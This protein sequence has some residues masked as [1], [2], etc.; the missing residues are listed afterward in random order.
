M[1][2]DKKYQCRTCLKRYAYL[3]R[4]YNHVN[5]E[6]HDKMIR[7]ILNNEFKFKEN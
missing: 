3:K 6:S 1:K 7:V 4:L 5:K 2:K